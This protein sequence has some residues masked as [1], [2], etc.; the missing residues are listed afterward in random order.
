MWI[1]QPA[2]TQDTAADARCM[3]RP[4]LLHLV[5]LL[6]STQFSVGLQPSVVGAVAPLREVSK[7][8]LLYWQTWEGR[9]GTFQAWPGKTR[10]LRKRGGNRGAEQLGRFLGRE[11]PLRLRTRVAG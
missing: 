5:T 1:K 7:V 4:I 3:T 6:H 11:T 2:V 8:E 9:E 10:V